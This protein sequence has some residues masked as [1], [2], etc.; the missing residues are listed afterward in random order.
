MAARTL[1]RIDL[2]ESMTRQLDIPRQRSSDVLETVL[3]TLSQGI[4]EEG[5]AK[6]AS[7]GTFVVHE[8]GNRVGRNP[9][10]GE[11]VEITPRKSLSFRASHI[12]KNRLQS[13]KKAS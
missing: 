2:V 13:V 5:G 1:T 7:F 11:E 9:R 4:V 3:K 12:L 6:I 10:T 8:K